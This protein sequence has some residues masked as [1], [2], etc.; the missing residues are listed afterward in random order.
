MSSVTPIET[1]EYGPTRLE[2]E[3]KESERIPEP[4]KQL[5]APLVKT[6]AAQQDQKTTIQAFAYTGKGSFIDNVF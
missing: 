6:E 1:S 3:R 4:V 5:E 2:L